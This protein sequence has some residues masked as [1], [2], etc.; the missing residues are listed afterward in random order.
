MAGLG[1]R[2]AA[3]GWAGGLSDSAFLAVGAGDPGWTLLPF[4]GTAYGIWQSGRDCGSAILT[5]SGY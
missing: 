3:L 4:G 2:D 1:L 5:A